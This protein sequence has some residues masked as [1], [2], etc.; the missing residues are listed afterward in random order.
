MRLIERGENKGIR[1]RLLGGVA[2]R[3]LCKDVIVEYPQLDRQCG[4]IDLAGLS[5]NTKVIDEILQAEGFKPH[6]EFN[7]LNVSSRMLFSKDGLKVDVILDEFRMN[8]RWPIRN[9]FLPDLKTLPLEDILLTKLQIVQ[10]NRKDLTDL[11]AMV[12]KAEQCQLDLPYLTELCTKKWGFMYTVLNNCEDVLSQCNNII[13]RNAELSILRNLRDEIK[14]ARKGIAWKLRGIVG[15]RI[16]WYEC[17][18]VPVIE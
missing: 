11:L 18:E 7:F 9:R 14:G 17:A 5:E 3:L 6:K 13:G 10:L 16:R 15:K 8:H 1:L 12:L 2:V 4:D